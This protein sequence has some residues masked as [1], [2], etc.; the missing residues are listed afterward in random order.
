MKTFAFVFLLLGMSAC[1]VAQWL[2]HPRPD[3]AHG[4]RPGISMSAFLTLLPSVVAARR[5][6]HDRQQLSKFWAAL[7]RTLDFAA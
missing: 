3:S 1:G 5:R 7:S 4:E 6:P 2:D